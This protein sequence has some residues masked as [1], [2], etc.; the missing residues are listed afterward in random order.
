ML[1]AMQREVDWIIDALARDRTK[2]KSGLAD[3]LNIDKSGV[4]RMLRGDRRL[5]FEEAQRAADYLGVSPGGGFAENTAEFEGEPPAA[6]DDGTAP[7]YRATAGEAGV[8]T[9]DRSSIIERRP[10]APQ[11]SG[12]DLVFG[13]YAPDNAMAPRFYTG[14]VVWTNPARPAATG[15]DAILML[16]TSETA[17]LKLYLCVLEEISATQLTGFQYGVGERRTVPAPPWRAAHVYGRG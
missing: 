10:R 2:T 6:P 17:S 13:F 8:W 9:I 15:E 4:S 3:A 5:K 16:E 11:F 12:A 14:E 1:L 7:L